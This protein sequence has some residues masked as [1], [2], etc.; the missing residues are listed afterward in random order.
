MVAILMWSG[1]LGDSSMAGGRLR[2]SSTMRVPSAVLLPRGATDLHRAAPGRLPLDREDGNMGWFRDHLKLHLM[3]KSSQ[4][5]VVG[6]EYS[7]LRCLRI[8]LE[9]DT[10]INMPKKYIQKMQKELGM[11][12]CAKMPT[13]V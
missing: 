8:R 13:P 3:I 9:E 11:E 7:H 6:M 5:I 10:F 12:D 1:S 4:P 2:R